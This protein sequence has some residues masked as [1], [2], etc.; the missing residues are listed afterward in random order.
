MKRFEPDLCYIGS[1]EYVAGMDEA[2]DGDFV[3]HS[4]A[5]DA[6]AA[7]HRRGVRAV[8]AGLFFQAGQAELSA[9]EITS[10]WEAQSLTKLASQLRVTATW[11]LSLEAS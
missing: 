1:G 6:L 4:D 3:L 2:S 8:I 5:S 11:L 7:E 9:S 10:A